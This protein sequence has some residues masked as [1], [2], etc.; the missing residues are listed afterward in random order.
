MWQKS[1]SILLYHRIFLNTS[2]W[3]NQGI[4]WDFFVKRMQI[5]KKNYQTLSI[6]EAR[7]CLAHN[8][9]PN[10]AVVLTFDDG[11]IEHFQVAFNVLSDLHLPASFFIPTQYIGSIGMWSDKLV[12][13]LKHWELP[14][15]DLRRFHHHCFHTKTATQR[16]QVLEHLKSWLKYQSQAVQTKVVDYLFQIQAF[17]E[18]PRQMMSEEELLSLHQRGFTIGSHTHTHPI[19]SQITLQQCQEELVT[20][21]NS[22]EKILSAPVRYFAYPNGIKNKDFYRAHEALVKKAGYELALS[23]SQGRLNLGTDHLAC[24]RT[25]QLPIFS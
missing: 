19:F 1:I 22:L 6:D 15:L 12:W 3:L 17:P 8:K 16:Q 24:P 11:Y 10:K 21:K 4:E 25:H 23:T 2:D 13:A 18:M 20:S 9:I 14:S 7:H 5:L